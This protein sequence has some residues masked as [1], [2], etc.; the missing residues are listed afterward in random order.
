[1][2]HQAIIPAM[3][4]QPACTYCG[5]EQAST[6]LLV[7]RHDAFICIECIEAWAIMHLTK[8]A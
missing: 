4:E 5:V 3:T 7:K 1:M 8:L 6:P 2:S